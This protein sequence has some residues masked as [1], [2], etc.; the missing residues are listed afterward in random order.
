MNKPFISVWG[1]LTTLV[2]MLS[3]L[4]Q[5]FHGIPAYE[6][7]RGYLGVYSLVLCL[8]VLLYLYY[9]RERISNMLGI[10]ALNKF[11]LLMPLLSMSCSITCGILYHLVLDHSVE[12]AREALLIVGTGP[13]IQGATD[14]ILQ[15][16]DQGR[17]PLALP[18][19]VL[20]LGMSIF[21]VLAFTPFTM[22]EYQQ[23]ENSVSSES[24]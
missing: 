19:L 9:A 6:R 21:A 14:F 3:G 4:A 11:G 10:P 8:F 16:T 18:L 20:Y 2:A 24:E 13:P 12:Q 22:K 5:W 15:N 1:S 7:Q 17:I 23:R